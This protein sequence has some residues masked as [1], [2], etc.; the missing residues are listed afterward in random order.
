[1]EPECDGRGYARVGRRCRQDG[2]GESQDAAGQGLSLPVFAPHEQDYEPSA[3]HFAVMSNALTYMLI[4]TLDDANAT[5]LLLPAWP[6]RWSVN[7]KL[8]APRRTIIEGELKNG[9]L[10]SLTVTPESR[11]AD[12]SVA[13]CQ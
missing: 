2:S 5:V 9:S 7:F 10:I 4:Q 6:C 3:D 1:M 12:V 11:R 13:K 8:H